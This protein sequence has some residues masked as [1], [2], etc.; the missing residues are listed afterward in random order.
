MHYKLDFLEG[1]EPI[2]KCLQAMKYEF[3][4]LVDRSYNCNHIVYNHVLYATILKI[5]KFSRTGNDITT[6]CGKQKI[7]LTWNL[8]ESDV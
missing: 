4:N 7:T 5:I 3:D 8:N 6:I 2:L 1:C